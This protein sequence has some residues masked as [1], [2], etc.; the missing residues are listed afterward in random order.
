LAFEEAV[1]LSLSSLA[2]AVVWIQERP[3]L[4][5]VQLASG[6]GSATG[7]AGRQAAFSRWAAAAEK[8]VAVTVPVAVALGPV[9]AEAYIVAVAGPEQGSAD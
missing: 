5:V 9:V 7:A 2:V 3:Q 8:V 1:P 4:V 6:Q